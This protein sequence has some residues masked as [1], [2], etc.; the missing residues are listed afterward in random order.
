MGHALFIAQSFG[1]RDG[2]GVAGGQQTGEECAE[3]EERCRCEQTA[4]GKGALH[5]VGEDGAEKA[6]NGKTDE[7]ARGRADERDARNDGLNRPVVPAIYVP[8]TAVMQSDAQFFVRTQSDPLTYL[9]SIRAAIASVAPDQQISTNSFNGT[10]TLNQAL[11]RDPQYSSQRLFSILFA[12]F[13]AMALALALVGI[14][15][16]V[17]YSVA[18]RTTEF[19]VQIGRAHV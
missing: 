4:C 19:G 14:F 8:Y 18:Q 17:A 1:R 7:N 6:V 3:S 2:D 15:S 12:V 10:L 16:V 9:N 13:S 11:E 5:P